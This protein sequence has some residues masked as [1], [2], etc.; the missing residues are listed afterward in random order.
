MEIMESV[1][2]RH[3]VRRYLKKEIPQEI[4]EK[5]SA[6]ILEINEMSNLNVQ[7]IYDD[8]SCFASPMAKYGKFLNADNYICMIGVKADDL[9]EKCGY[10]G[11]KI[12]LKAQELGL[13]TCWAALTHGSQFTQRGFP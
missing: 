3:S 9:E 5:L 10:Y 13:N 7:V 12:V 6:Y 4:R 8:P 1:K 11:E 2:N